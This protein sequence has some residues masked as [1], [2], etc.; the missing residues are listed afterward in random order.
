MRVTNAEAIMDKDDLCGFI[1]YT[2]KEKCINCKAL[3]IVKD[4]AT[5]LLEASETIEKQES[6]IKE[7]RE[8]I[9]GLHHEV[10]DGTKAMS[11]L[12]R[13]KGYAE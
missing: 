2:T 12:E 5:D 13:T 6:I 9:N 7:M 11:I 3:E 1:E 10:T 8:Y 4:Y